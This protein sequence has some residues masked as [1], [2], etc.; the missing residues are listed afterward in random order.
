MVWWW[1]IAPAFVGLVGLT[2]FIGGL[3]WLLRGRLFTGSARALFGA[4]FLAAAAAV[5][6]LGLDLQT[7]HRLTFERPVATVLTRQKQPRLYDAVLT[8]LSTSDGQRQ[9]PRTYEIHGDEW[10]VEARVLKWKPW[11]N[12]LGLDTQ[13]R[14]DRLSG[15]YQDTRSELNAP[16]S[17]Y[18][19][20][21]QTNKGLDLWLLSRRYGRYL[22]VVDTLYGS[23]ASMP[24]ADGALYEVW[25]TQN[26]LVARPI[27]T[28]AYSAAGSGWH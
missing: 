12:V 8:E 23:G 25:I 27:N 2:I 10:R 16:R 3:G 11:A 19:L 26:G 7:Y 13:Y 17:A 28:A 15:R 21:P 6:L 9:A 14:L 5:G 18:D 1:W 4:L 20:G 24:M 22:P